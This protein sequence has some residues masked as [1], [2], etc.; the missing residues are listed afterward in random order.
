MGADKSVRLS[1]TKVRGK[2]RRSHVSRSARRRHDRLNFIIDVDR[3]M[4]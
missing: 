1:L 4:Q 3:E 2:A